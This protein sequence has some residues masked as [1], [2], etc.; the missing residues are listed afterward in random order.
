MLAKGHDFPAVTLVGVLGA[1]NG[2]G[3][4][5]FRAA[6]RTFQLLTQVAGRSG[7]GERLGVVLIQTFTPEHYSLQYAKAQDFEGFYESERKFR[8]ALH[9]PPVVSLINIIV[10]GASMA[11]ATRDARRAAEL[12]R[13]ERMD[14]VKV[15]GPAF[16]VRSKLAGR[17]RSQILIKLRKSQHARVRHHLRELLGHDALSR[18]MLV[19]V[20]PM[21][22]Y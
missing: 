9:Y 5:D 16:A 18:V 4:P 8:R 17:Y 3:A 12:L 20:D 10:E 22:M 6:E 11:D 7:R 21:T 2:L 14:G 15:L 13:R 19:D 1:D